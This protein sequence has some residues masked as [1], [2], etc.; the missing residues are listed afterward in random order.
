MAQAVI[1]GGR[2]LSWER[3]G[4][5]AGTVGFEFFKPMVDMMVEM[6]MLE[7]GL[8]E[9]VCASCGFQYRM[10]ALMPWCCERLVWQFDK[11]NDS[12]LSF[13]EWRHYAE[14]DP[15]LQKFLENLST[16]GSFCEPKK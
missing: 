4:E 2:N 14:D 16:I 11:D 5:A 15:L 13:E 1:V 6:A 10:S 3:R 8:C 9:S 12:K 7:V